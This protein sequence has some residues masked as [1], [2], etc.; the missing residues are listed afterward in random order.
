[1]WVCIERTEG[2]E[3][4][5]CQAKVRSASLEATAIDLSALGRPVQALIAVC[6]R[7]SG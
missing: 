4:T 2:T 3:V 5:F 6:R 1:M 7:W